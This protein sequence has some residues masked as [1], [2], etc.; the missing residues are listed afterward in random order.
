MYKRHSAGEWEAGLG[1][2]CRKSWSCSALV[3]A[4]TL[5]RSLLPLPLTQAMVNPEAQGGQEGGIKA[6]KW[7]SF[8][9]WE[10]PAEWLLRLPLCQTRQ[11]TLEAGAT[12][13]ISSLPGKLLPILQDPT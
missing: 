5:A 1:F 7:G 13:S 2:I 3:P 11:R 9:A 8:I 10:C 6:Q 12:A 4:P